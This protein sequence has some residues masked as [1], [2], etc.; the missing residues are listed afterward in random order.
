VV[1]AF[2]AVGLSDAK[3]GRDG[4]AAVTDIER[5]IHAFFSSREAAGAAILPERAEQLPP[6]GDNLVG[7]RLVAHIPD[8]FIIRVLNA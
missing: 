2:N 8:D 7:V 1:L 3:C 4:G 5:V 6:P